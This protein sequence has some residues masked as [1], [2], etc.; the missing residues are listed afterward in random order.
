MDPIFEDESMDGVDHSEEVPDES[1]TQ[2]QPQDQHH[3][4]EYLIEGQSIKL[5]SQICEDSSILSEML[6][7]DLLEEAL[8]PEEKQQLMSLMPSFEHNNEVEQQNTWNMLF[9]KQNVT[10]GNP[11]EKFGKTLESGD[12]DPESVKIRKLHQRLQQKFAK[13]E[14]RSYYFNLL[15]NVIVSRQ[16]LI[17]TAVQLPPGNDICFFIY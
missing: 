6:S 7:C 17:E 16:Q 11:I 3:I 2:S 14:Q 1:V 10:F 4:R 12:Y 5:P 9:T 13:Q 8:R 15:Q